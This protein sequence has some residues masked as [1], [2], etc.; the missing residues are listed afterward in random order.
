[1]MRAW[2]G[3]GERNREGLTVGVHLAVAHRER[4]PVERAHDAGQV[5]LT[6]PVRPAKIKGF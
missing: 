1:V 2:L 4:G 5:R 3:I 6:G